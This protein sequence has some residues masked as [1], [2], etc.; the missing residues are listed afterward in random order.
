[1]N[2]NVEVAKV[3]ATYPI[4]IQKKINQLRNLVF[5]AASEIPNLSKIEETLKWGE[6][7]YLVK[8]GSTIRIAWKQSAPDHFAIYFNCQTTLVDTFKE[9]YRDQ[10]PFEGNRA[11]LFHVDDVLPILVVKHCMKLALTYHRIKHLPLL[12]I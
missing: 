8:N 3:I 10:C 1:M 6:P 11:M 7:S 12:G 2:N 4:K 5:E 9:L